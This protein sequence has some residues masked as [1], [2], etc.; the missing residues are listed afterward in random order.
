MKGEDTINNTAVEIKG[1]RK[2]FGSTEIVKSCSMRVEG[3][4]IYGLMGENG[5]GKT[6]LF[7]ILSGLLVPTAGKLRIF[8]MDIDTRRDD[9]LQNIGSLIDTPVFYEHLS[10]AENLKLHLSYM[11]VSGYEV[12]Q[13]LAL[14]GLEADNKTAVSRYS[15]G[16]RQRLA[17][18]RAVCHKPKLLILDEPTIGLD[19]IGIKEMRELFQHL[20]QQENMTIIISTHILQ[21]LEQL[22]DRIGFMANGE[23]IGE[24]SNHQL[25]ELKVSNLEAYFMKMSGVSSNV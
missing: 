19:P 14:V 13:I 25:E 12:E 17:I 7:K 5:A 22:T 24:I 3:Q 15:L 21:E 23:L 8:D 11:S 2:V 9:I 6:T 20:V 1:L 10:A 16:M 4:T 18:A